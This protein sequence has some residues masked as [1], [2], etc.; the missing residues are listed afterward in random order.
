MTYPPMHPQHGGAW[1]PPRQQPP[2]ERR[3]GWLKW[4]LLVVGVLLVLVVVAGNNAPAPVAGPAGAPATTSAATGSSEPVQP[5]AGS[6]VTYRVEGQG[7]VTL[8]YLTNGGMS[9]VEASL[10]WELGGV[11]V[12]AL[13]NL[14]ATRTSGRTGAIQCVILRDGAEIARTTAQGQYASCTATGQLFE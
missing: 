8:T 2:P 3:R 4:V 6:G 10:P 9:Q 13:P 11:D 1:P 7:K 5:A 14:S 12:D